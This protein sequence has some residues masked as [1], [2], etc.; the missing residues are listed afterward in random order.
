MGT[1]FAPLVPFWSVPQ[2][3]VAL[4]LRLFS[5]ASSGLLALQASGSG[6]PGETSLSHDAEDDWQ[7]CSLEKRFVSGHRFSDAAKGDDSERL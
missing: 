4:F 3:T 6:V 1:S 7:W 2:L 5:C